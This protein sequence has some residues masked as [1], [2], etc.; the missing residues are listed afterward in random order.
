VREDCSAFPFDVRMRLVREGTADLANVRVLDTSRYAVSAITFPAYFL[1]AADDVATVQADLDVL[2]FARR[3]APF[4]HIRQ[5]FF[6]TEPF[7]GTTRAYNEAMQRILP[8]LGVAAVEVP[9][10]EGASGA[11]SASSVRA[12]LR[13]GDRAA[14][15]A[16]VPETTLA[17]LL[18][19]EARAV[20]ERLSASEGRHA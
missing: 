8:M 3:I 9:R 4:F 16:L 15:E 2:L 19:D 14:L 18:S 17:F 1:D 11:I 12:A 20:R 10:L 13:R 7:C 6:G 5:R